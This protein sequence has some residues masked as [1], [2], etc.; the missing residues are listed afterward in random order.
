MDENN[1][2]KGNN[3]DSPKQNNANT[4]SASLKYLPSPGSNN[5][6]QGQIPPSQNQHKARHRHKHRGEKDKHKPNNTQDQNQ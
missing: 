2:K 5:D 6:L 1:S 3:H 4:S